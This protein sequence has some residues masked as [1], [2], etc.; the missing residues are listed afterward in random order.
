[1]CCKKKKKTIKKMFNRCVALKLLKV[2]S[3]LP[4]GMLAELPSAVEVAGGCAAGPKSIDVALATANK[5]IGI[6]AVPGAFTPTCSAK[7]VPGYVEHAGALK[8]AGLDEIWCVSVND[9]W[10]MSAWGQDQKV[11]SAVRMLADGAAVFTKDCGFDWDLSAKGFGVRSHRYSMIVDNG[12][13]TAVNLEEPGKFDVSDAATL[14]GQA[15]K[16]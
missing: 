13:V 8:S 7:H 6:F 11:G 10:V 5:K 4:A 3:R 12:V 2:G 14:L 15:K 16:K 9:P 1:M